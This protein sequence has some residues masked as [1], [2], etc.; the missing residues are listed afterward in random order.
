MGLML[1]KADR[2]TLDHKELMAEE[3]KM[4]INQLLTSETELINKIC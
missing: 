1:G 2:E 3:V 4:E